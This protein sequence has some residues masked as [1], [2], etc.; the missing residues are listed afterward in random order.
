MAPDLATLRIR[1]LG[2]PSLQSGAGPLPPFDSVRVTSLLAY[3]LVNR[4][5]SQPR[6]RVAFLLWPDS[7]EPQALTN[8][9]HLLHTL[10][11]ALPDAD[12][13]LHVTQRTVGWRADGP[14]WLDVAAFEDALLRSALEEAVE[15]Y[16]G[17]L[18]EGVD[19][20]WL[21][22]ERARL[23]RLYLGALERLAPILEARGEH[24]EAILCAERLL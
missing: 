2:E 19:E 15:L 13:F 20:P 17:D 18:L 8:L 1:L 10:R 3:L 16:R 24:A 9:R 7:T 12:R 5:A 11:R 4:H 22:P 6:Q 21:R 23:L 14:Y